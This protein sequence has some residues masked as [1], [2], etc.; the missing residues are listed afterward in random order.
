LPKLGSWAHETTIGLDVANLFNKKPPYVNI[1]PS[2]NGGGGFDATLTNPIDR[3]IAVS[4]NV[5]F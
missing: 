3:I 2:P 4:V 5:K 1:A